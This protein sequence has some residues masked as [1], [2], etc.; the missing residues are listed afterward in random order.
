M[1]QIKAILFDLD[2]TLIDFMKMKEEACKSALRAMIRK[3]LKIPFKSGFKRLMETYF[4]VGIESNTAFE[5]FLKEAGCSDTKILATGI[6]EYL[7]TKNKFLKPYPNAKSTL[8]KLKKIGLKLAIVTDAPRL[9]A[10]QRLV[11]M[12]IDNYFDFV[13]G[14]EDT[15]EKKPS[16]LPFKTAINKLGLKPGEIMMIGDSIKRDVLTAKRIGMITVL[17]KYSQVE[18][19]KGKADFEINDIN[20]ILKFF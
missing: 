16:E 6:N 15:G 17:A 12:K 18:K 1:K 8:K 7:K 19:E 4:R 10:Y 13:V 5:E 11:A 9:K 3:G 14:L 2:N 20:E